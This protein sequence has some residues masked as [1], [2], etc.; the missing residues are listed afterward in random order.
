MKEEKR[1]PHG[2]H[3][4]D[5]YQSEPFWKDSDVST[6]Y[7]YEIDKQCRVPIRNIEQV[8]RELGLIK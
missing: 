5:G 7:D 4:F 6:F 3:L 2:I 8:K 1:T